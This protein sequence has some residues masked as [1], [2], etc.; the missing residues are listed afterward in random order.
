M[1]FD[2]KYLLGFREYVWPTNQSG[3]GSDFGLIVSLWWLTAILKHV[4]W[5][6]LISLLFLLII[7]NVIGYNT[8]IS[9]DITL[10]LLLWFGLIFSL[11][12]SPHCIWCYRSPT[13]LLFIL[14]KEIEFRWLTLLMLLWLLYFWLYCLLLCC[15]TLS[16]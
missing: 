1:G 12:I 9:K 11:V 15:F 4:T 5:L 10:L 6:K 13:T 16:C 14:I 2:C 3:G 7:S 8:S